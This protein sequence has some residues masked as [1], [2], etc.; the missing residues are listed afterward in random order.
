LTWIDAGT[1]ELEVPFWCFTLFLV[2]FKKSFA[3]RVC[4][5]D[6]LL[7]HGQMLMM[8]TW[9]FFIWTILEIAGA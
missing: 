3:G 5:G 2:V 1:V 9:T 8:L 4:P 6:I 7:Q